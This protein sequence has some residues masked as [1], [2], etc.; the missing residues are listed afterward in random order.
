MVRV[1]LLLVV[2]NT[3]HHARARGKKELSGVLSSFQQAFVM[4]DALK[5]DFPIVFASE[6]FYSMTGYSPEDVIGHNW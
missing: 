2:I 6:G 5:P 3:C 1:R 4:S